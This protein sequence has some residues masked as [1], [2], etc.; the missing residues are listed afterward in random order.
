MTTP[1]SPLRPGAATASPGHPILVDRFLDDAIEIDVDVLY[2]GAEMFSAGSWS[3]SR[4]P[5]SHS[6]D[7]ACALPPATLGTPRNR[8]GPAL[9][10]PARR[11]DR[12][13][14]ADERP[15]RLSPTTFSTSSEA[16]PRASRTVPFVAKA[17]GVPLAKAAPVVMLGRASRTAGGLLRVGDGGDLPRTP[18]ISVRR[19]CCR[20]SGSRRPTAMSTTPPSGPRCARPAR[21]WASTV[22]S[23]RPSPEPARRGRWTADERSGLRV[24]ANR[25]K[26]AMVFPVM[27]LVD[28]GFQIVATTG[29]QMCC[30]ATGSPPSVGGQEGQVRARHRRG[31][32][33][34]QILAGEIAMVVNTPSGPNARADGYTAS[35]RRPGDGQS[36]HHDR[37]AVRRRGPG[38]RIGDPRR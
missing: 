23:A 38:H 10:S 14:R 6:G 35:A 29:R 17:T 12:G 19:R 31:S 15:V 26:R 2:D 27:R 21:S 30:A 24:M 22:T 16:N 8:P 28:L 32:I 5:A 4:R 20:S 18:P 34:D 36:D 33:V 1:P 37:P 9:R 7:S 13:A 3:T 11:G 25:D